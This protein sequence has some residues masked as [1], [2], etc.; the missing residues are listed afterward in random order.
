MLRVWRDSDQ[1]GGI[2]MSTRNGSVTTRRIGTAVKLAVSYISEGIP[3]SYR[4]SGDKNIFESVVD[5]ARE[6]QDDGK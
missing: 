2:H 4:K 1:S 6:E 5:D 3:F